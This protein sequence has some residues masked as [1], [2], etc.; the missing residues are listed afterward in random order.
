MGPALRA[1]FEQE[2]SVAQGAIAAGDWAKAW[3]CLERAHVLGQRSTRAH[4]RAHARMLQ[5][6]WRR[7]DLR[8]IAG[9]LTRIAGASVLTWIWIPEGNT[10]GARVSAFRRMPIP[11]DLGRILEEDRS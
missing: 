10:G 5:F 1:A 11:A 6:A 3:N 7:R 2:Q 8:E 4:V 9:Q